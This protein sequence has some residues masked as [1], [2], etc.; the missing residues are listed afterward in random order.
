[1]PTAGEEE[2]EIEGKELRM[3]EQPMEKKMNNNVVQCHDFIEADDQENL[4]LSSCVRDIDI[5]I[6]T[7]LF[8]HPCIF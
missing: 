5:G 7:Y 8:I 1:M 6:D 4:N 3:Y 2:L